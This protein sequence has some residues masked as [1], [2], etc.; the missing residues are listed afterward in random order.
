L[1]A[2]ISK[3][4]INELRQHGV[5]TTEALAGLPLPLSWK[6]ERGSAE[7]YVR[8]R[9][10]ARIQVEARKAGERRFELLPVE[11]GFGLT[12]LPVPSPGDVFLDLEGD[13][14]AGEGGFEYLFGYLF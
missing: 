11:I 2:G 4:Q 12:R 14:F 7:S 13:P 8:V 3:L 1:V 5:T 6:P 9:E 10:H